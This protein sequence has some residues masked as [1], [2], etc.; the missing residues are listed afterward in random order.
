MSLTRIVFV[1]VGVL[2][3]N[4]DSSVINKLYRDLFSRVKQIH[5]ILVQCWYSSGTKS[6][7][8]SKPPLCALLFS[9]NLSKNV[10]RNST[11]HICIPDGITNKRMYTVMGPFSFESIL[12]I[13]PNLLCVVGSPQPLRLHFQVPT[14]S[15]IQM[16]TNSIH[17]NTVILYFYFCKYLQYLTSVKKTD[18]FSDQT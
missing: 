5:I 6:P 16:A 7:G 3:I 15:G 17:L 11:H 18:I 10:C 9:Q 13:S 2:L 14:S 12:I 8:T 1:L 4:F